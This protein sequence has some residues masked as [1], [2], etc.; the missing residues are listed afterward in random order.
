MTESVF[1]PGGVLYLRIP[2]PDPDRSA[3]FYRAV[4]GWEAGDGRFTDGS[5][6]LIG[7]FRTDLP[8]AGEAGIIP[9]VYVQDIDAALDRAGPA[10]GEI[11][12]APYAEGDL[13]VAVLTDPAG[14]AIGA[15]QHGPR[16]RETRPPGPLSG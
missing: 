8:V 14:N 7:H 6:L 4:F 13:W 5:G 11:T 15:W 16:Q 1:R 12:T 10:G 2:A 9:Y 3:A